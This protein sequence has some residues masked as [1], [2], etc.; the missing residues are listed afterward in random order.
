MWKGRFEGEKD[1]DNALSAIARR[2][3]VSGGLSMWRFQICGV[4]FNAYSNIHIFPRVS[5]FQPGAP[6]T[7]MSYY[8][9]GERR[10]IPGLAIF[11]CNEI[12]D[13]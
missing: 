2:S 3:G 13:S 5:A 12:L 8:A 4:Q 10:R 1:P 9:S 7:A 11:I 6:S